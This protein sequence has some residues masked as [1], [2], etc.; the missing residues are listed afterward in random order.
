MIRKVHPMKYKI[1]MKPN[2]NI[3]YAEE[4]KTMCISEAMV[5]LNRLKVNIE[6]IEIN[7]I[8]KAKY[9]DLTTTDEIEDKHYPFITR[10]SFYYGFFGVEEINNDN[11]D[12][13]LS[14][15][16]LR[17]ILIPDEQFFQDDL[18]IRLKYNG[19]TNEMFTRMMLNMGLFSSN[20]WNVDK[21]QLFDPMC[22]KGTTLFEGMILGYDSYG[23]EL[24]KK[25]FTDMSTYI[26]RYIKEDRVKHQLV[27]GKAQINGKTKGELLDITYGT[28][29][30]IKAKKPR[31]LKVFR[32]DTTISSGI[33][34]KNS[35]HLIVTDLPYGVQ[36]IGNEQGESV[37]GLNKLIKEGVKAWDQ[38]LKKGGAIVFSW[39]TFT[40]KR[41]D[42][43][44]LLQKQNYK[45]MEGRYYDNF[46]HRVSQAINRDILVAI[47]Q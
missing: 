37:R 18:S 34:K 8:G 6:S 23:A 5:M 10:L 36:H 35:I 32:G 4:L 31:I 46:E 21:V 45:V 28:K 44:D 14:E 22:G 40:D 17:P 43:I 3:P 30:E 19:K 15:E 2:N 26:A 38:L 12:E 25:A 29:A 39:N 16:L 27:N 33:F 20:Y 13:S 7:T 9:M 42:L 1:L 47:K 41:E 11:N 24:N